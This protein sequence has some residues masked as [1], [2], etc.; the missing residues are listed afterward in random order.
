[1]ALATPTYDEL[2]SYAIQAVKEKTG[3]TNF[4]E[5]SIAGS[6]LKVFV[7]YIQDLYDMLAQLDEQGNL[8]TAAGSNLDKIGQ[9]FG[10]TRLPAKAAT[11]AGAGNAVLFRN[12]GDEVA[13]IP[14]STRVWS[15]SNQRISY[16]TDYVITVQ[17]GGE[18]YVDVTAVYEGPQYNVGPQALTSNDIGSTNITVTNILPISTGTDVESDDN[19]RYRISNSLL[20]VQGANETS[21]RISLLELPGVKDVIL[22][23]MA[24]GT[25]TLDVV[26][27]SVDRRVTAALLEQV[28][29]TLDKVVAYG[30]SAT[31]KAPI[32]IPIDLTI[33]VALG[34]Q[35]NATLARSQASVAA[36]S[37]I[38][39]LPVGDN[40]STLGNMIY[41][42]LVSR[43]MDAHPDITNT[44]IRM[45]VSN[46]TA[47]NVDLTATAGSKFYARSLDVT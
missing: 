3:I 22:Q 29:D 34:T 1:M 47:L 2:L 40:K 42:E 18:S 8:S 33:K 44:Q 6:M 21:I 32:E 36:R 35:L 23:P 41:N 27:I 13:T 38:D 4:S 39:N 12:I 30:I 16:T 26:V 10:V 5:S 11:T 15:S 37:Y 9:L 28:Q 17:S 43:V 20:T 24:R 19:Y 25:G 46:N 7:A 31:A 14:K 45:A